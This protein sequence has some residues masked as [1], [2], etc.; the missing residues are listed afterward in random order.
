MNPAMFEWLSGQLQAKC[1]LCFRFGTSGSALMMCTFSSLN[2]EIKVSCYLA[3][4]ETFMNPCMEDWLGAT[5]LETK[6]MLSK[7][8]RGGNLFQK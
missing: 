3:A 4:I 2:T 8:A 6:G 1:R 5:S 7:V